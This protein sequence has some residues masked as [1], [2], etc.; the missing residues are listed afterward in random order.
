[1]SFLVFSTRHKQFFTREQYL[2]IAAMRWFS[3]DPDQLKLMFT[4][5]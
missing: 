2:D 1:M 5:E 4:F 3:N